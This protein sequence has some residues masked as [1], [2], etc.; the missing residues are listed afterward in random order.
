MYVSLCA[1]V[2]FLCVCNTQVTY[3]WLVSHKIANLMIHIVE[4]NSTAN[5]TLEVKQLMY[6]ILIEETVIRRVGRIG[7][8]SNRLAA[9]GHRVTRQTVAKWVTRW[10]GDDGE[11]TFEPAA[12]ARSGRP[13]K[14][15][16]GGVQAAAEAV[17]CDH[18]GFY[19]FWASVLVKYV[20]SVW[21]ESH[22]TWL[23]LNNT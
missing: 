19:W 4:G 14:L 21:S 17:R 7:R 9:V 12:G 22:E 16:V 18:A 3:V 6:R 11:L 2:R 5:L 1:F 23:F 8:T 10:T 13:L 15:S 20:I